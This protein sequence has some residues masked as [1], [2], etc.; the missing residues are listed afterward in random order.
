MN[1][2]SFLCTAASNSVYANTET[3][4]SL[5]F[6]PSIWESALSWDNATLPRLPSRYWTSFFSCF[7]FFR[8]MNL[9]LEFICFESLPTYSAHC[10]AHLVSRCCSVIGRW[11]GNQEFQ[12]GSCK[13]QGM[14]ALI[15][16]YAVLY[17][18]RG[19]YTSCSR[20]TTTFPEVCSV[21]GMH[22][23]RPMLEN[24]YSVC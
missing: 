1:Q 7:V 12:D 15:A 21:I 16:H 6:S 8:S 23:D 17:T 11:V 22:L 4:L 5:D 20:I 19:D 2:C 24:S 10:S 14:L 18:W 3:S 13:R 9:H